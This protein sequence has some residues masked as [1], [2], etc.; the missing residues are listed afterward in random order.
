MITAAPAEVGDEEDAE[1][2]LDKGSDELPNRRWQLAF[3]GAPFRLEQGSDD[4]LV[5]GNCRAGDF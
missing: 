1:D 4:G 3:Q 5:S 2:A